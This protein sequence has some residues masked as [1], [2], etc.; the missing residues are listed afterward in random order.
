MSDEAELVKLRG[1]LAA[2]EMIVVLSELRDLRSNHTS[3]S[4]LSEAARRRA[5]LW[6]DIGDALEEGNGTLTEVAMTDKLERLGRLLI[7]FVDDGSH[8]SDEDL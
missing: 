5:A 6:Q 2:T 4:A 8:F 3:Q 1:R 7:K